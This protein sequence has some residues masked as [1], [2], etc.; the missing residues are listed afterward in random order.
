[1]CSL[2]T[3]SDYKFQNTQVYCR[4]LFY[5]LCKFH[6]GTWFGVY[7][8]LCFGYDFL[9]FIS[10]SCFESPKVWYCYVVLHLDSFYLNISFWFG[11]VMHKINFYIC[12]ALIDALCDTIFGPMDLKRVTLNIKIY[13]FYD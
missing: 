1:M 11:Y 5:V 4:E 9:L 3:F 10:E 2:I 6:Y 8:I 7:F 12:G 13:S